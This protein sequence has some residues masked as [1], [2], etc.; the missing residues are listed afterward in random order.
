MVDLNAIFIDPAVLHMIP[1]SSAL[2][3]SVLPISKQ[4]GVVFVAVPE[5]FRKQLLTDVQFILGTKKVKPIPVSRENIVAAIHHFY[6]ARPGTRS[7]P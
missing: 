7:K 6:S 3:L 5:I 4:D 2:E 1:K